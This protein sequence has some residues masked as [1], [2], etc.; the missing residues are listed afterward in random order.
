MSEVSGISASIMHAALPADVRSEGADAVQG[1]RG[2]LQFE[3]M[4]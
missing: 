1:Y 2:A 3:S 4:L